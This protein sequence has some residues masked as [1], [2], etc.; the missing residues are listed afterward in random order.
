[1]IARWLSNYPAIRNIKQRITAEEGHLVGETPNGL[2]VVIWV[3]EKRN[4]IQILYF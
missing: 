3:V 2:K 4:Y 1:V